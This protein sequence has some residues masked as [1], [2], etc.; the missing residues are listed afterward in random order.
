MDAQALAPPA[1]L[2]ER[3]Q[4]RQQER[5][6]QLERRQQEKREQ[7]VTEEQGEFFQ[8][9]F[10]AE[11]A[12]VEQLLAA[13]ALEEAALRLQQLR[14]FLSDS[15]RFLPSYDL[16]QAQETLHKLQGAL[17]DSRDRLKPKKKFAFKCR[18]KEASAP[19]SS[20]SSAGPAAVAPEAAPVPSGL[21]GLECETLVKGAAEVEKR[22][23]LLSDLRNCTV[24]LLGSPSAL[25]VR[26]VRDSRVLCGPVA[27]SVLVD[28]CSGCVLAFPCQQLRAHDTRDTKVYVQVTSR[29]IVEDC[30]GIQFAPFSWSYEGMDRDFEISGLD[31]SRNNWREV[32]DFNWLV[33]DVQ[34]PNWSIIP[35]R[36]RITH[37]D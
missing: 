6:Q 13:P 8:R 37:W 27:T 19:P 30:S 7:K 23:V 2:P 3:L 10:Q 12:A 24:K 16:R 20:S 25:H 29:A 17:N 32:D 34:S 18:K 1:P 22:D 28:G 35:E 36:E 14:K 33:R 26:H 9:T 31:R 4:R 15:V 21:I 5:Q 11:R